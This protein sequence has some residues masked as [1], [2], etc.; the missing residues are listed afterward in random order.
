MVQIHASRIAAR[1]VQ[2]RPG[3]D[4]SSAGLVDPN[5]RGR[6]GGARR[7]LAMPAW[8]AADPLSLPTTVRH[9]IDGIEP[10]SVRRVAL[11]DS[12]WRCERCPAHVVRAAV[13]AALARRPRSPSP[14]PSSSLSPRLPA[15]GRSL[16]VVAGALTTPHG[17]GQILDARRKGPSARGHLALRRSGPIHRED[18]VSPKRRAPRLVPQVR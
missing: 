4:R 6:N 8:I 10:P 11:G 9:A 12:T 17:R 2:L 14:N 3:R 15:G 16:R 13:S 5:T 7:P 1:A 18:R